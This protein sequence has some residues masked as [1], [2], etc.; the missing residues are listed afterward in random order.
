MQQLVSLVGWHRYSCGRQLVEAMLVFRPY[1]DSI[2]RLEFYVMFIFM[3]FAFISIQKEIC[4][5]ILE[6]FYCRKVYACLY[7]YIQVI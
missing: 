2:P 6:S 1:T 5:N 3:K 4:S 7:M